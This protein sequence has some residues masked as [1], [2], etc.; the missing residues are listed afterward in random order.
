[1]IAS[2]QQ[3]VSK[4]GDED[5]RQAEADTLVVDDEI[6]K[7]QHEFDAVRQGFQKIPEALKAMPKMNPEGL[8]GLLQFFL[9]NLIMY[10]IICDIDHCHLFLN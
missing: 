8:S 2:S 6:A 3:T 9:L 7:I 5:N 10:N 4:L 1:V